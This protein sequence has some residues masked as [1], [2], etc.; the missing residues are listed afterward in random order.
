MDLVLVSSQ[1]ENLFNFINELIYVQKYIGKTVCYL[2]LNLSL[3]LSLKLKYISIKFTDNLIAGDNSDC[4]CNNKC[5]RYINI[6]ID[7]TIENL[8]IKF[9]HFKI[10]LENIKF[11]SY[12]VIMYELY[13]NVLKAFIKNFSGNEIQIVIK[14]YYKS[15]FHI[16]NN[17]FNV[18]LYDEKSY[19][20]HIKQLYIK[21]VRRY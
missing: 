12:D 15:T 5:I 20:T 10:N 18:K 6:N 11:F 17:F 4:K 19:I 14:D 7:E 21:P 8:I 1:I 2:N 3:N 13:K 9:P 16:L